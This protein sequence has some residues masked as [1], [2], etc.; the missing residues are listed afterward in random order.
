MSHWLEEAEKKRNPQKATISRADRIKK[1]YLRIQENLKNNGNQFDEFTKD[2]HTLIDRVNKLPV[3]KNKPFRKM[4]GREKVSK[5]N[6]HLNIFA[7]SRRH[8]DRKFWSF[9]PFINP[10]HF[11]H[12][13]VLYI[14][15]SGKEGMCEIELKE[16]LLKRDTMISDQNSQK[17][18]SR[19]SGR[20]HVIY[21]FPISHLDHELALEITDWLAF[22]K[23]ISD[24]SFYNTVNEEAKHFF[25]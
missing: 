18:K 15:I 8:E 21:T 12:I 10:N 13:R 20:F 7:S 2:L 24:C 1:R 9:L 14:N 19:K 6:N 3:N 23:E 11:K 4:E 22:S 16:N 17:V 25:K 5:L